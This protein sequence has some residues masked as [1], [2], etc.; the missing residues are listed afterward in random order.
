MV[1][2]QLAIHLEEYKIGPISFSIFKNKL[3]DGLKT[4]VKNKAVR[5][6]EVHL[7]DWIK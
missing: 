6:L 5:I 1:L 4:N 3:K 7:R 2:A